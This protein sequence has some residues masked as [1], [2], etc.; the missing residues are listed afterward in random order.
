LKKTAI[1]A[2]LS[3]LPA[4]ICL[5]STADTVSGKTSTANPVM[6]LGPDMGPVPPD[7]AG[8]PARAWF[9]YKKT[10][11]SDFERKSLTPHSTVII[12][13]TTD[14]YPTFQSPE[15]QDGKD[16]F[17]AEQAIWDAT[18]NPLSH[19]RI[20]NR[21]RPTIKFEADGKNGNDFDCSELLL[22]S[23]PDLRNKV[24]IVHL[25]SPGPMQNLYK[26]LKIDD[27]IHSPDNLAAISV[28]N[29]NSP[30]LE[31]FRRER[32]E[33]GHKQFTKQVLLAEAQRLKI[34]YKNLFVQ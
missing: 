5:P 15:G 25:I 29:L 33:F 28:E 30:T 24:V 8:A 3:I 19:P 18:V 9:G 26:Q 22:S 16:V 12:S 20:F 21:M 13:F 10:I 4:L 2:I 34:K 7:T 17:Y 32:S 1:K 23:R 6:S 14:G 31:T 27:F 11:N